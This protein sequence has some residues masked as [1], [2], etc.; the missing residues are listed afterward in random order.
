MLLAPDVE[1]DSLFLD[2]HCAKIHDKISKALKEEENADVKFEF[3]GPNRGLYKFVCPNAAAKQWALDILPK[4]QGVFEEPKIKIVDKGIIPRMIKASLVFTDKPPNMI[5]LC[6]EIEKKNA[7]VDTLHWRPYKNQ[8]VKGGKTV[9]FIGIDE[10][11]V[12]ALK[13][14]GFRAYYETG[15]IKITVQESNIK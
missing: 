12:K 9:V 5:D 2:K 1:V 8:K 11:S 14:M 15:R 6:E 3:C 13:A 10:S 4:L 7:T